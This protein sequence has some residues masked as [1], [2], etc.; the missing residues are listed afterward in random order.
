M[1]G[2]TRIKGFRAD[3]IRHRSQRNKSWPLGWRIAYRGTFSSGGGF[4]T[5]VSGR[6]PGRFSMNHWRAS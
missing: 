1:E 3:V 6:T 5:V 2:V 4:S